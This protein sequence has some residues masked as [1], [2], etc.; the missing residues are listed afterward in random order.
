MNNKV[1]NK[2]NIKLNNKTS[3]NGN[4]KISNK[5]FNI[6]IIVLIIILILFIIYYLTNYTNLFGKVENET[7]EYQL[8]KGNSASPD[9]D[10]CKKGCY[11]GVC[12]TKKSKSNELCKYD[13]QC[14]YCKDRKSNSFYVDLTNY[15]EVLPDYDVQDELSPKQQSDLNYEIS[16]NNEYIEDL[17]EKI[18]E[19]NGVR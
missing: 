10:L 3:G 5:I 18:R 2:L 7:R 4:K 16:E 11:R 1:N 13:F 8:I 6:F 15:E 19:Y 17:N 9:L 12:R 14:N